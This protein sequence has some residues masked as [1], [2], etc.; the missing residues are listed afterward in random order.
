MGICEDTVPW[1]SSGSQMVLPATGEIPG[2]LRSINFLLTISNE[3]SDL[4]LPSPKTQPDVFCCLDLWIAAS[5]FCT[6]LRYKLAWKS[7]QGMTFP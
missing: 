2:L 5:E 4:T 7:Q 3:R 1:L 6:A